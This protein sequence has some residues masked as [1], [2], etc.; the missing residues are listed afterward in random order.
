VLENDL[1]R[2]LNKVTLPPYVIEPPDILLINV[3]RVIP[4]PPYR[5]EPLDELVIQAPPREL[6]PSEPISGT[7]PVSPEGRVDLAFSYGQVAVAGKTIEEAAEAIKAHLVRH[8]K[9]KAPQVTVALGRT[10]AAQ[11]V[12]GE[13]LVRMDGTVSLGVYGE[14][15]LAG[16]TLPQARMTIEAHLSRFLL[17][18]QATVDVRGYN[19]KVYYVVFDG[20]RSGQKLVRMPLVGGET[21][22]D[23]LSQ[24][25]ELPCGA[26][27]KIWIAR[28]VPGYVG[29]RQLLPVDWAAILEGGATNTNYQLFPGDRIF[30]KS[31]PWGAL[32][33]RIRGLTTPLE[34]LCGVVLHDD[35]VALPTPC[36][37]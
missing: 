4:K 27:V 18:P 25:G 29:K 35:A 8:V 36:G 33:H 32:H 22:L 10:H 6:L 14:V 31:D 16:M 3:S 12:R 15:Y 5:I 20:G 17:S 13:Y 1:P 28:P 37:P 30:V 24:L 23:A 9:I 7:Y 11:Q 26:A 19:S 2:E 21:V 34:R